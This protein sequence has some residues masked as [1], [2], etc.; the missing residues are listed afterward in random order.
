MKIA[1]RLIRQVNE[2]VKD[3]IKKKYGIDD[4]AFEKADPKHCVKILA[5]TK[6]GWVGFSHRAALEFKKGDMLFDPEWD[7]NGKLSEEELE[8]IP[9]KKRGAIKIT[10]DEQC[11][12]A[13]KNF[14]EYVS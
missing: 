3:A 10:N 8:K 14:A 9:F 2:S 4:S 6:D 11:R 5:K 12:E 7:D 13:A 1:E